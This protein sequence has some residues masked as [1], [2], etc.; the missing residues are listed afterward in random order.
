MHLIARLLTAEYVGFNSERP[1][2]LLYVRWRIRTE[3]PRGQARVALGLLCLPEDPVAYT[4]VSAAFGISLGTVHTHMRRIRQRRPDLYGEIMAERRRQLS[5][6]HDLVV[7]KRRR[8]SLLWARRRRAAEYRK[9]HGIW[10]WEAFK[11]SCE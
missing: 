4:D 9:A 1:T 2:D 10:P 6:R 3:L 5:A 11:T 8:R 7:A